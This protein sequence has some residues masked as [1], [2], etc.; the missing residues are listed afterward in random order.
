MADNLTGWEDYLRQDT[1]GEFEASIVRMVAVDFSS[2]PIPLCKAEGWFDLPLKQGVSRSEFEHW[3]A[4]NHDGELYGAICFYWNF[5]APELEDLDLTFGDH[6]GA[7]GV[8]IE[9]PERH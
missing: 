3:L 1:L 7:E 5:A 8:I 6:H 2:A 9:D 4:E